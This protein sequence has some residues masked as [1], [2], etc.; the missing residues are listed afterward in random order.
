MKEVPLEGVEYTGADIV[1][2]LIEENRRRYGSRRVNFLCLDIATDEL[3]RA[4]LVL[5]RDA[6]VHLSLSQAMSA[7]L[8]ISRSG[9]GHLLATTF[10][11]ATSN[12]EIVTG[13]FRKLNLRL[14][15]FNLPPPLMMIDEK[16]PNPAHA[17]KS[18]GL[19]RID[20]IES[21]IRGAD[22]NSS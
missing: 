9:G 20:K 19:W 21:A 4:D 5:V 6:L 18:L 2:P 13:D 22:D 11:T 3:P 1:P 16:H 12:A 8:R 14:P 10:P 7:L 15:P 17:D